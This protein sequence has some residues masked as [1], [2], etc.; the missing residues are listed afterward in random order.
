MKTQTL[1]FS[2]IF[3]SL[4]P[5]CT[6]QLIEH[7]AIRRIVN[8]TEYEVDIE[9]FGDSERYTYTIAPFGTLDIEGVCT[10]GIEEYCALDW[11]GYLNNAT[12]IFDDTRIQEFNGLPGDKSQK[13]INADP[14]SGY[15]YTLEFK[16]DFD[17]Y[18]YRITEN[19]YENARLIDG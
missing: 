6:E 11:V 17:V 15:G 13:A 2:L 19:D 5:A 14:G 18:T 10:S 3:I 1:I 8:E 4:L 7:P 9:V 16:E 12:I